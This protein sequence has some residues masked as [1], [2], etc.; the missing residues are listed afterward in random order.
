MKKG[1]YYIVALLTVLLLWSCST[2]KNTKASRFY[3]AFTTRYNIY[4][5]GKQAFDEAL[6]S[7][8]DGYKENYS[9]RIYMYPISAQPKDKAEPGG[10]F[11]RTIEK[12][13]KAIKLHSIKAKP[14]K[15]PGWR[16]NPKLRAIQEQEEY[17]PAARL[18]GLDERRN[19]TMPISC[20]PPLPF[21]I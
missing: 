12:S 13:N 5:N 4:F 2:K 21:P 8:Q 7:Q 3:H 9:D 10:P 17:N 18:A 14:A 6:K 19:S 1:F 11:D 16:N 20:K 15:K